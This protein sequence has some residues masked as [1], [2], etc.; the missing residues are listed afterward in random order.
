MPRERTTLFCA[1]FSQRTRARDLAYEFERFGRLVRCDIP[2]PRSSSSKAFAF[3]EFED[4]RDAEDAYYDLQG[5]RFEGGTL[6]LQWAKQAPSRAWRHD[7][8]DGRR[9]SPSRSRSPPRHRG[10]PRRS[11]SLSPRR[12]DRDY[13]SRGRSPSP[14]RDPVPR[15]LSRDR[16]PLPLASD[17][18]IN[19]SRDLPI[20]LPLSPQPQAQPQAQ[21]PVSNDLPHPVTDSQ[22]DNTQGN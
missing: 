6:S 12:R 10:P 8:R 1:G 19:E 14:R 18:A 11:P 13:G 9:R 16:L 4:Y 2:Q 15:D 7:D 20:T 22:Q 5:A 17:R 3:V 21:L